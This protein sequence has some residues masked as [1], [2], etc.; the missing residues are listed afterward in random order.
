MRFHSFLEMLTYY[1]ANQNAALLYDEQGEKKTLRYSELAKMVQD[2]AQELKNSGKTSIGII[3]TPSVECIVTIFAAATAKMQVVMLDEGVSDANLAKLVKAADADM[4]WGSDSETLSVLT[5]YLTD[6]VEKDAG[7]IL[8]FTSGT[9]SLSKAVVL[10]E[11]SLCASAYNGSAKLPLTADDTLLCL[12]PLAHVFGFICSLLWGLSCGATV[13]LGR[14]ARQLMFDCQYFEPTAVSLVPMLLGFLLKGQLLNDNLEVILIGA[15]NC[16][17]SLLDAAAALGKRVCFGYGLTETSSGVA[18]SVSG[19]PHAM[20][21]CPDDT[22]EIAPDGEILITAPTCVMQ[23]YYKDEAATAAALKDG[24]LY[25]G[26]IGYLDKDGRLHITGRKK[27]M[28]V[29]PNGTKIF[30]P[31]YEREIAAVLGNTELAVIMLSA[32]PILVIKE[33]AEKKQEIME[34]LSAVMKKMPRAHQIT[35]VIFTDKPLPRTA[36]GKIKRWEIQKTEE[37]KYGKNE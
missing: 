16:P 5:P 18:I 19:D 34:K 17:Q 27:E 21:V 6:G 31:D 2:K 11:E 37:E 36:T 7:R 15:G 13:A 23:G 28:L 35:D 8:F 30:L 24:V 3:C 14:G 32:K 26:D 29:L 1:A 9:T 20:E 22:I 10:T 12:L 25:S 4:L 33:L